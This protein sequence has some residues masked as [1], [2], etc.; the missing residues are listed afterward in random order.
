VYGRGGITGLVP[1]LFSDLPGERSWL[2]E[3]VRAPRDQTVLLVLDGVGWTQLRARAEVAPTLT[4]MI[5]GPITSVAP[6][7]TATALCSI[8]SGLP[9]ARHGIVGYRMRVGEDRVLNALRWRT[10]DGDARETV[11]PRE[12]QPHEAFLGRPTPVVTRAEFR[13]T[14]FTRALGIERL[15][16][17]QSPS[18]I[19]VEVGALLAAGEPFVYA[20]YDGVDK[21]AHAHG[22]GPHYD[23]ELAF[24]DRLVGD[25]AAVLPAGAALVV[26]ADHGQVDVGDRLVILAHDVMDEVALV[27]GEARFLWLHAREGREAHLLERLRQYE[28]SG[29]A[30]VRTRAEVVGAGWFGGALAPEVERRLGDVAIVARE[31]VAFLDPSDTGSAG[32]RCRHGSLTEDELLVPLVAVG[33][34]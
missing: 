24:V 9:P 2:P 7:T 16:G 11:P 25:V 4:S 12:M 34:S 6:T 1:A 20:Y 14:G 22:F 28:R 23:A 31:P 21:I 8:V 5:G 19:A 15:H 30:L 32:L 26:T 27:S 17:W 29:V 10:V 18:S 33:S 13:S 3:P